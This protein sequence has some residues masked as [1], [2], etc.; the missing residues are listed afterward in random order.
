MLYECY[1]F[2]NGYCISPSNPLSLL[3]FFEPSHR[4]AI[5][6]ISWLPCLASLM[7][8]L[9]SCNYPRVSIDVIAKNLGPSVSAC[10]SPVAVGSVGV[11]HYFSVLIPLEPFHFLSDSDS[12]GQEYLYLK[13]LEGYQQWPQCGDHVLSFFS[14]H[15]LTPE[16][17][18]DPGG[19]GFPSPD[20]LNP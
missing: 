13:L 5:G 7:N 20:L 17:I 10:Q 11:R 16:G 8:H 14:C 6:R 2:I 15:G 19:S 4:Q 18:A 1:R 3:K 12:T 9:L